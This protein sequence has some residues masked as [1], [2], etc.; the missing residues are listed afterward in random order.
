MYA[1]LTQHVASVDM[2]LARLRVRPQSGDSLLLGL[3]NAGVDLV[4]A[5]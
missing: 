3:A 5:V 2:A 1:R 4:A